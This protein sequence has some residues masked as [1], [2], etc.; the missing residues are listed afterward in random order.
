MPDDHRPEPHRSHVEQRAPRAERPPS[1]IWLAPRT[2]IA[3]AVA[4]V[5]VAVGVGIILSMIT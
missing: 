3:F 2:E 4:I 5:I 1:R